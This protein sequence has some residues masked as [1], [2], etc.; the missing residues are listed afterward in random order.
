MKH[1][2]ELSTREEYI[3]LLK[4]IVQPL[5][6]LYNG[7]TL[8]VS[9]NIVSYNKATDGMEGFMRMLVNCGLKK[10]GGI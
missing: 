10:D 7:A 4:N 2:N 5:R 6:S 9:E 1:K 3:D 8:N